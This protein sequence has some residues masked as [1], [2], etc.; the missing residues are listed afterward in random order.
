MLLKKKTQCVPNS[1]TF[2]ANFRCLKCGLVVYLIHPL[3]AG[4]WLIHHY[5]ISWVF[6]VLFLFFF[7]QLAACLVPVDFNRSWTC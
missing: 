3:G 6:N 1:W 4:V 7:P 2:K 5:S